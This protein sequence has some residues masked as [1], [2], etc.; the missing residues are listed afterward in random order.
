M[1]TPMSTSSTTSPLPSASPAPSA[2]DLIWVTAWDTPTPVERGHDPRSVYAEQFWLGILG[3]STLWLLRHCVHELDATPDGFVLEL[4]LVA[5]S[6]GL[7]HRG[8]RHSALS[9]AIARA[10]RFGMAR[11]VGDRQLEVRR[12]LPSLTRSQL[13]RLPV[14]LQQRH[15]LVTGDAGAGTLEYERSR[16]R[17][18][19][20]ALAACGE[21]AG[22]I[23]AGLGLLGI[24][25][26]LAA[27][28]ARA[29]ADNAPA[30]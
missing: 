15:R 25:P 17:C 8:G 1:S 6:L 21:P 28:A 5:S 3:P 13:A 29:L 2:D 10:V 30:G 26:S 12:R 4:P 23:E 22:R 7:G 9:R 27:E 14:P 18:L 16:A 19:A 24:H 11:E 20:A